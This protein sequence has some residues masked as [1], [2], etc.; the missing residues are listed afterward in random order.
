MAQTITNQASLNYQYNGQS[1][2]AV[3]NV[4]SVTL[5]EPLTA[6][7]R[8]VEESY[9]AN[10]EVTYI[11]SFVNSS[12]A[13]LTGITVTDNL[14]TYTL[15]SGSVTP[16][17][18]TA[19]A[20]LYID[21]VYS[22]TITPTVAPNSITF[23]IPSLAA[24][25]NVQII[26]KA[27]VNETAAVAAA[28][29]IRNTVEISAEG[30][31][32]PVTTDHAITVE[33]YADVRIIKSMSPATLVDGTAITYEFMVYNYG[34]TEATDVV[35]FDTFT[36]APSNLTV[37]IDGAVLSAA[38]YTYQDGVLTV[39]TGAAR[40]LTLPAAAFV[41]DPSTGITTATPSTMRIVVTG[42]L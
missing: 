34:N 25:S 39:P 28:S 26:Y 6:E 30:I 37:S 35:L 36:P 24:C 9:R 3:S 32:T 4:A 7:K 41:Q 22:G 21:G 8:S 10:G 15:L 42:N 38:D 19:P 40:T 2:A 27:N 14:G 20:L 17:T 33:N 18:F 31:T 5:V 29:V 13:P 23:S 12:S 1:A 11:L 16:L